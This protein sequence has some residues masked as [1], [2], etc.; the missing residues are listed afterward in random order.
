M[1]K[2][3]VQLLIALIGM[4]STIILADP[5]CPTKEQLAQT[6]FQVYLSSEWGK[7]DLY[8]LRF[9]PIQTLDTS[10]KKQY[11]WETFNPPPGIYNYP[12]QALNNEKAKQLAKEIL[13]IV[14]PS[15]KTVGPEFDG[16]KNPVCAYYGTIVGIEKFFLLS[17]TSRL[18]EVS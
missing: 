8:L 18:S 3:T 14:L 7:G 1:L 6:D 15:L 13:A 17:K 5:V 11:T 10:G 4:S 9:A 12:I 16:S 2:K